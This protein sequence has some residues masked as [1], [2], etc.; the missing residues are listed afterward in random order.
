MP[1]KFFLQDRNKAR[2]INLAL[3][4]LRSNDEITRAQALIPLEFYNAF[5][6][7]IVPAIAGLL[8]REHFVQ[9]KITCLCALLRTKDRR[10]LPAIK[11]TVFD[12]DMQA[13]EIAVTVLADFVG[14]KATIEF[15]K[16]NF[17]K[18]GF[19]P[20]AF[21]YDYSKHV[22]GKSPVEWTATDWMPI[23][24]HASAEANRV[25]KQFSGFERMHGKDGKQFSIMG[26]PVFL[27]HF[28]GSTIGEYSGGL[29]AVESNQKKLDPKYREAIAWH[30]FGE[31]FSHKAGTAL[32]LDALKK[33]GL[34]Q[35]FKK[36]Y[37]GTEMI[38]ELLQIE[39][40][41]EPKHA[42]QKNQNEGF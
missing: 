11:R 37:A 28:G 26:I 2:Q 39:A 35:E 12:F 38:K 16:K 18:A 21:F 5:D 29:V 9:V 24:E 34:W 33:S 7:R 27:E 17:R 19:V 10:A 23:K 20:T 13:R 3:R 14:W 41:W 6:K 4:R 36:K 1:K 22:A 32:Q 30:E 42:R 40:K 31:A 8:Q 25:K 15:I